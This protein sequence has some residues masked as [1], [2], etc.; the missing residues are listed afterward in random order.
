MAVRGIGSVCIEASAVTPEGRISPQDNGIWADSHI[1]GLKRI[2]DFVH[3]HGTAIGIQ[4]AHAGRKASTRATFLQA[5][6]KGRA[7]HEGHVAGVEEGG[8]PEESESHLVVR[9][10]KD[11][12]MLKLDFGIPSSCCAFAYCFQSNLSR[13]PGIDGRANRDYRRGIRA[14]YATRQGGRM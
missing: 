11:C 12:K 8:W 14:S 7:L 1:P 6:L 5:D 2:V 13:P 4:L 3:A 10:L 9:N